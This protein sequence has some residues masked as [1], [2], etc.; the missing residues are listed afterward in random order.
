MRVSRPRVAVVHGGGRRCGTDHDVTIGW[1][2]DSRAY[3]IGGDGACRLTADHSWAQLQVDAGAMS[4]RRSRGRSTGPRHHPLARRRRPRVAIRPIVSLR[5][6]GAG[7]PAALLRRALEPRP[8][9]RTSWPSWS[10]RSPGLRSTSPAAMVRTALAREAAHDNVTVAVIDIDPAG[11]GGTRDGVQRRDL[12]ERVPAR[13]RHRRQRHRH[14]HARQGLEHASSSTPTTAV[15]III[16][17][18]GSMASPTQARP[19]QESRRRG[20]RAACATASG[21]ASSPAPTRPRSSTPT[22][23][24]WRRRPTR[25]VGPRSP[26]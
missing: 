9:R 7:P 2:G 12:P 1:A 23:K 20:D 10:P 26:P 6:A 4:R 16:D 24:G 18:S 25:P 14:G 21:S 8:R 19:G 3:W 5:P 22:P 15:V 17:V 11:R 13:R